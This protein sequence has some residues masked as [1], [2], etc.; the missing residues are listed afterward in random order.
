[1]RLSLELKNRSSNIRAE[2]EGCKRVGKTDAVSMITTFE[3]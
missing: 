3:F 1:M 2:Q